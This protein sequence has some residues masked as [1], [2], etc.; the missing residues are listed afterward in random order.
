LSHLT[1]GPRASL[2]GHRPQLDGLRALAVF[3]VLLAHT[4]PWLQERFDVGLA[5]VRLFFV[6]SG[7][8]ITG[9]LLR[10]RADAE[11]AGATRGRILFAFYARRFL[12]IFPAYYGVLL[13]VAAIDLP[14]V[15][16]TLGWH[17]AYLSN[18]YAYQAGWPQTYLGHLWSLS[19]EEQFYLAWPAVVLFTPARRLPAVAALLI[20][21][22]PPSRVLFAALCSADP[23]RGAVVTTSCLDT[24]GA[25]ALLAIAWEAGPAAETLRRRLRWVSLG[26][27]L[28]LLAALLTCSWLAWGRHF[29]FA[30]KDLAYAMIF[31][32]LVDRAGEGFGGI[33]RH[34][35][36]ARPVV[37]L[38]GISYGI[39]LYHEFVPALARLAEVSLGV[40]SLFP[41]EMGM[42]RLLA[43]TA[44]TI[45]L[46][47]LSWHLFEKPIN[48]LKSR[49]PYVPRERDPAVEPPVRVV[50]VSRPAR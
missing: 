29:R 42:A 50:L 15:R 24:L 14:L 5:G 41:R 37:Y 30:G 31:L 28:V 36:E 8:L 46:A 22:G 35:L 23:W 16:E 45:P 44:V 47:A 39:Y 13:L 48:A 40:Q 7:F 49:F 43:V 4:M 32:W 27:G 20:G 33:A 25:G 21:L 1:L 34:L 6:L 38:G 17:L 18:F 26:L 19:V 11:A 2:A 12:R 3:G 10:A 9:I